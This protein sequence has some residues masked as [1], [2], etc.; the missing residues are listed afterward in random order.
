MKKSLLT[1]ALL[2]VGAICA[3]AE[4]PMWMRYAAIS[5]DGTQ[6]AF[7][8]KGDIYK[9]PALG[10]TAVQLTTQASYERNP[11]WSPDGSMIAFASDRKGNFDVYVMPSNGGTPTRL[12]SNS[13][14]ELPWSFSADGREIYFSA[15]RRLLRA[16]RE[17]RLHHNAG[18]R[19][20]AGLRYGGRDGLRGFQGRHP[21]RMG[22]PHTYPLAPCLRLLSRGNSYRLTGYA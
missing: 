9:V 14:S 18:R 13:A 5:P 11:V 15:S 17:R 1:A 4:S 22:R 10:G 16:A 3:S 8:Y 20:G 12:T 19:N 21:H 2:L 6:I 7:S